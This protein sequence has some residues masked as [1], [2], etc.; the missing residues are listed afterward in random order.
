[1]AV[2]H[3]LAAVAGAGA[4]VL[5][6]RLRGSGVTSTASLAGSTL[7][8]PSAAAWI[9]DFLNAAYYAK[10]PPNR[11]LDDLRLAFAIVTTYWH[12]HGTR[13]LGARDVLRFHDAFGTARLRGSGGRTGTLDRDSLLSGGERLFGH[14]FPSAALDWN[15][16]GWGI[17]FPS[18]EAK[19]GHDPEVRLRRA[20]PGP[21]SP[22]RRPEP[23]QVWHTY[24]PVELP[25]AAATIR[26]L[27]DVEHWPDYAS[28]L[29]RF[30]PLRRGGLDGQTFEIEVVGFPSPRTPVFTRAY[31][32]V[33][34]LVTAAEPAA[35]DAWVD[36]LRRGFASRPHEQSPLP[37]D[38]DV[39]AGFDLMTHQGHFMGEAKNRLLVYSAD[40]R[41]YVRAAG[42]W[43][44]MSWPLAEM[45]SRVGQWSQHAFW[46]MAGPEQSMLHQLGD[47]VRRRYLDPAAGGTAA[48]P[49]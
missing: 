15:R 24:P 34:N 5:A 26:A 36:A 40:G 48:E 22:P 12:E 20:Q 17:V 21:L 3:L 7:A 33:E 16:A 31:V 23:E 1:M 14:W 8:A 27:L 47:Q 13:R 10:Q 32:T 39:H 37:D 28:E 38:A 43:D 19:E 29:G 44:P 41:D 18:V 42:T 49:A 9:T 25:D 30:T 11:D 45:Y 4:G 2:T 35:R 46:G 6:D